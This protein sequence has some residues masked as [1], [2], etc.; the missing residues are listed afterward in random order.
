MKLT[1][2]GRAAVLL[3]ACGL[4]G[5]PAFAGNGLNVTGVGSQSLGMGSADI[6]VPG[7]TTAVTIN[8]ANLT[9]IPGSRL[10]ASVEPFVTYGFSHSDSLNER[11]KSDQAYGTLLNASYS[12]KILRPDLTFGIGMFVAGGYG[13]EYEDL[14]TAFGTVDEYSAI[15]GVT[16]MST[17]LGWQVTPQLSVGAAFNVSYASIRQKLFPNTS[18][19]E[20]GFF[21]LRL[22]GA[23][24]VSYNGRI[25][26]L[27]QLS[28]TIAIGASYATINKLKLEGG[29][30]SVN[31]SAIDQGVVRYGEAR[32]TGFALP[33]DFGIG[34]AWQATPKWLISTEVTWLDWSG[35][36][37]N[38]RLTARDPETANADV[39]QNI[40]LVQALQFHDQFV[41][42]IGTAYDV[43]DRLRLLAG[44]NIARNPVPDENVTPTINLT[45]ELEFDFGIRY[46]LS[47]TW[48]IAT[49]VQY[50]P[51]KSEFAENP[52]QPFTNARDGYGVLGLLF[53]VSRRW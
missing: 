21:G 20:A 27:Y 45:Q 5:T 2:T 19:A 9:Q 41:L 18:N 52:A 3:S 1:T 6:A 12:R 38:V 39:P 50:Q 8:P 34:I 48:E 33:Q 16:R 25:G 32:V 13:T 31:Y 23:D 53:E 29:E 47:K 37:K 10:D 30:L 24:G 42:A 14:N 46:T 4:M 44:I 28:P 17:G 49:A 15:F 22:D 7:S 35:A 36:A 26:L 40:E 43:T 11:Q 51:E